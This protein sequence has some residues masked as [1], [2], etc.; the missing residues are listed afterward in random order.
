MT[1][2]QLIAVDLD[3]TLLNESN[4]M[5]E[6]VEK[7]LKA[8]MEKGVKVVIATGKTYT[9]A[10]GL[11]DRLG[12]QTSGIFAQ[13]LSIHKADG[14][15]SYQKTLAPDVARQVITFAED[16][17]FALIAYSGGTKILVRGEHPRAADLAKRYGEPAPE[18]VGPLQ[19]ILDN[20]PINK[21]IAVKTGEPKRVKALRWQL[22]RQLD[23]K[24]RL[25]QAMIPDMLEILPPHSSKGSALKSLLKEMG[26]TAEKVLAIGDGE[27]DIEMIELAGIGVAMGNA[28]EKLKAVADHV[29]ASNEA[30]GVAEAVERFVIG[31]TA[32]EK[33]ST[34][35]KDAEKTEPEKSSDQP[36]AEAKT[37]TSESS[38]KTPSEK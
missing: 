11:I 36:V 21:L 19:N 8:A 5:T 23:G 38:E 10:I 17:G 3:G 24:A 22:D 7:A 18:V 28:D 26:I 1:D 2:I 12:L 15:V 27:N 16:R 13:G 37:E 4:E 33:K 25:V 20:T 9:S 34:E 29:V 32:A 14:T 30:D 35:S 6:R 31:E